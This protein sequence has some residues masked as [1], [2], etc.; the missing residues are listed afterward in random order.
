[1]DIHYPCLVTFTLSFVLC[2]FFCLFDNLRELGHYRTKCQHKGYHC[3]S[4]LLHV[5]A[6]H[7]QGLAIDICIMYIYASIIYILKY[8][9]FY[10]NIMTKQ[11]KTCICKLIM[12]EIKTYTLICVTYSCPYQLRNTH[13]SLIHQDN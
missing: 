6:I 11:C 5:F 9:H 3:I 4:Y 13:R 10:Q 12:Y 2:V 8:L 7:Q 1:M